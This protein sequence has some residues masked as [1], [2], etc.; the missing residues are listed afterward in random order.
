MEW[1]D[2]EDVEGLKPD[3]T[4]DN[5]SQGGAAGQT[6]QID[7]EL[8]RR[9]TD[10]HVVDVARC[11]KHALPGAVHPYRL[12]Q[13]V[14]QAP[15]TQLCELR[16]ILLRQHAA[17]QTVPPPGTPSGSLCTVVL[18]HFVG[19]RPLFPRVLGLDLDICF[20]G[21]IIERQPSSL[22]DI[23][24]LHP[25]PLSFP[26]L[27]FPFHPLP[28]VT[29]PHLTPFPFPYLTFPFLPSPPL[30]F[31]HLTSPYLTFPS[32]TSPSL[33]FPQLTSPYLAFPSL[34]F[35]PLFFPFPCHY[36]WHGGGRG[37]KRP[38]PWVAFQKFI[39]LC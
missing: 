35:P 27:S 21:T 10:P 3:G 24:P 29:S 1:G 26:S 23:P 4:L 12:H 17:M 38:L 5:A 32:L 25:F 9:V 15:P 18:G 7:A 8:Y 13:R 14:V 33:P 37:L 6:R 22:P 20:F 31:P 36:Q 16:Q 34:L 28:S 30:P 11:H 39:S 2:L 19:P